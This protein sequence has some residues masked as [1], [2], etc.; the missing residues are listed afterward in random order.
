MK[1]FVVLAFSLTVALAPVA[2][3]Q[4]DPDAPKLP[5][6]RGQARQTAPRDNPD[7]GQPRAAVQGPRV[8]R[9]LPSAAVPQQAPRFQVPRMNPGDPRLNPANARLRGD[10]RRH[11]IPNA[12]ADLRANPR[13]I[14]NADAHLRVNPRGMRN[15]DADLRVNPRGI[16]EPP[17]PA[18][19]IIQ[20]DATVTT[21]TRTRDGGRDRGGRTGSNDWNRDGRTRRG[22]ERD[23]RSGG[24]HD[25][26]W[27]E[28]RRRR[29]RGHH[30][31]SWWKSR[32]NRIV[33]FG[34]GY[35]YW[36]NG[37]WF[38]AYGYD[39]Y[40]NT[41]SYHEPIYGYGDLDPGQ[42]VANVQTELQRLGYYPYAVDGLMGPATRAA[43]AAFQRDNGL[44]ITSAI[45]GP[46]LSTLGL[47]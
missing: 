20:P 9:N 24:S 37:F 28:A 4:E 8:Q 38:P 26:D 7:A 14:P 5:K 15:V 39:P 33:L 21:Q 45:D 42:V 40:Y 12:D 46:T 32:Y 19:T 18:T 22:G 31:R 2:S 34:G 47:R 44:A 17:P 23:W 27:A 41:Y 6:N 10:L 16:T 30:H 11:R 13:L 35:Y 25:G 1:P 36:D 3:A 43:I 29:H